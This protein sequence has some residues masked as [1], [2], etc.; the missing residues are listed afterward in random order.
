MD[1]LEQKLKTYYENNHD[2]EPSAFG[3][4]YTRKLMAAAGQEPVRHRRWL[5]PVAA[6]IALAVCL[7]AA[8]AWL[9]ASKPADAP[10]QAPAVLAEPDHPTITPQNDPVPEA[11]EVPTPPKPDEQSPDAPAPIKPEEPAPNAKEAPAPTRPDSTPPADQ[12]EQAAPGPKEPDDP[13]QNAPD[14][15]GTIGPDEPGQTE[16]NPA[17][18]NGPQD[19][20]DPPYEP[21]KEDGPEPPNAQGD[22]VY[23]MDGERELLTMT[24]LSTGESVEIDVTGWKD[25]L[26]A[27]PANASDGPPAY[28]GHNSIADF[29]FEKNI[30]YYLMLDDDGTVCVDLDVG[31]ADVEPTGERREP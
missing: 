20:K 17:E 8:I 24:L 31:E 19:A 18:Q 22:A 4:E 29:I 16:P 9:H 27:P 13:A 1:N 14:D 3:A 2:Y 15:P 28:A 7:G 11:Q 30:T 5:V 10:A 12:T 26:S 23:R 25:E 21:P 6:L